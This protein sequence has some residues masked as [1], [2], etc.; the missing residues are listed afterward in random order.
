MALSVI[1]AGFG[2]TGTMSLK[3][4]LEQLG[5]GPC[6]HMAEVQKNPAHN[7][8]WLDATQGRAV[9]WDQVFEGYHAACDWPQAYFWRELAEYYPDS[10]IILTVRE[11]ARWYDSISNT[12]F[13]V[14]AQ[15]P[16]TDDE[17]AV[18]HRT[19]TRKIVYEGTFDDRWMDRDHVLE[20]Y[21]RHVERVQRTIPPE[22]LLVYDVAEGWAP[23]CEFLNVPI[24]ESAFPRVNSKAEFQARHVAK[25]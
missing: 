17:E 22:R 1:G 20:T 19:M 8:C 12:I 16:N 18:I 21:H 24:P 4:A 2:R 15:A 23:L 13:K 25:G 6:Y 14:L 7:R 9:D 5:L 10:R 3:M 11:P